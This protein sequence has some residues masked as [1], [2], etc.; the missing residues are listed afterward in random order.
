MTSLRMALAYAI[1]SFTLPQPSHAN[2]RDVLAAFDSAVE[3]GLPRAILIPAAG[4][5]NARGDAD[6]LAIARPLDLEVRFADDTSGSMYLGTW[7]GENA[8]VTRSG[9]HLDVTVPA[10]DGVRIT[11]FRSGD[12]DAHHLSEHAPG[13][14]TGQGSLAAA[15]PAALRSRR[16]ARGLSFLDPND[17]RPT[18]TFWIFLHDD[19][20]GAMSQHVHAGYVGWWLADMRRLLP[21]YRLRTFYL[22]RIEGMTDIVYGKEST[23]MWRW[24]SAVNAYVADA[25]LAYQA[26]ENEYKFILLTRNYVVPET[27]GLA[28]QD[29]QEAMASLAG[30]WSVIAHEFGH[31]LGGSHDD[32]AIWWSYLWPCDTNLYPTSDRLLSNCYR[33]TAANERRI[34]QYMRNAPFTAHL[35]DPAASAP[36]LVE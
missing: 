25:Q 30:S 15:R 29:G 21:D 1:I 28:V 36:M 9:D 7:N 16:T 27:E 4:G 6:R 32:A 12:N 10:S 31:T 23:S 20:A 26:P 35:Q 17:T 5:A 3:S 2:G 24:A 18:L 11:G 13:P 33:Y 34:Q 19:T 22:D 14:S 8:V